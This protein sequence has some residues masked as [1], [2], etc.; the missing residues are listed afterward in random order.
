LSVDQDVQAS[1]AVLV[2]GELGALV[3]EHSVHVHEPSAEPE[4]Q[5]ALKRFPVGLA[6]EVDP[7]LDDPLVVHGRTIYLN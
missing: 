2:R 6:L 4:R 7:T 5:E 3:Q 1:F